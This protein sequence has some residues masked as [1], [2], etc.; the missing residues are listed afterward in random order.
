M[1]STLKI[2]NSSK[3]ELLPLSAVDCSS[4]WAKFRGLMF[5]KEIAPHSAII[6]RGPSESRINAAIH[7]LFM[8]FDIAV[9]WVNQRNRVADV[10][11]ARAWRLFYM[12][13]SPACITIE[14][15]SSRFGDY[16][17]GDEI[18]I[19]PLE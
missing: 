1:H 13:A 5:Q 18:S 9:I 11:L 16:T 8:N 4:F 15:H 12:P 3:P 2:S 14:T 6:F 19:E 7:M 17:I 10:Q